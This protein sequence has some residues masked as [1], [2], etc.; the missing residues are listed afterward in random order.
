MTL[1]PFELAMRRKGTKHFIDSDPTSIILTPYLEESVGGTKKSVPQPPRDAQNFKVIWGGG[2]GIVRTTPN[3]VHRFDF[4]LVG[5]HD[6]IVS[7]GDKFHNKKAVVSYIWP[8]NEYEVKA[9]GV[10]HDTAV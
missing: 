2:D 1:K 5:E 3:G 9:G 4:I 7:I 8:S 10:I 6:A